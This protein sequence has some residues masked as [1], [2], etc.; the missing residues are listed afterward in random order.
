MVRAYNSIYSFLT[1]YSGNEEMK[2][3]LKEHSEASEVKLRTFW[4]NP[5]KNKTNSQE[6]KNITIFEALKYNFVQIS[7]F[8]L[9]DFYTI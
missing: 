9:I 2:T 7:P 1:G 8:F 4:Q 6:F 3:S 5:Q